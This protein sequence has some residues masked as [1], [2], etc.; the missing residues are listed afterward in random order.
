V[1]GILLNPVPGIDNYDLYAQLVDEGIPIVC[2]DRQL[3]KFDFNSVTI[4]DRK[5]AFKLTSR[6]IEEGRRKILFLGPQTG[7]SVAEQRYRGYVDA[8][9]T[10][11]IP[12]DPDFIVYCELYA[13]ESYRV[14]KNVIARG[15][16]PDAVLCVGGLGAYGAGQ[17][18]LESQL[19]IPDEV[20]LAEFGD[21][22]II[23]RLGVPF[24]TISQNPYEMGQA[25]VDLLVRNI[26]G[27]PSETTEHVI[28]ETQL[29]RRTSGP[30]FDVQ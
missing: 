8:L 11:G 9:K 6:L 20:S 21:N 26:E 15:L 29:I 19:S 27:E 2:Y 17:A 1:D 4:D 23:S 25:A 13:D 22:R 14:L 3:T 24:W 5:A 30:Q 10:Y 16:K 12:L 18:I 28:I 7:F